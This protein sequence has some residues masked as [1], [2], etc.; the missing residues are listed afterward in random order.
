[1]PT[2]KTSRVHDLGYSFGQLL[3]TASVIF[4]KVQ[5]ILGHR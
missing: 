4:D 5:D 3:R 1:M 2:S